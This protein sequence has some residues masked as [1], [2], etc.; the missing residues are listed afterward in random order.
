MSKKQKTLE[1]VLGGSKNI[2]FSEFISLVEE[3]GFLLD[4]TNGSHHIFIHPDIPDL[5]TIYSASR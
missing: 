1:K 4:R 5:V 2:S 3:F